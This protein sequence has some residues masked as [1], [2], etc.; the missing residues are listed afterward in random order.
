MVVTPFLVV[1][2]SPYIG[3]FVCLMVIALLHVISG[4]EQALAVV[5]DAW[6]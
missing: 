1:Q 4:H 5:G 2:S 6:G 3:A